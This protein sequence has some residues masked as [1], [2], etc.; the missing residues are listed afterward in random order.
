MNDRVFEITD[1]VCV[2]VCVCLSVCLSAVTQ[3]RLKLFLVLY[4]GSIAWRF[5][6]V[7]ASNSEVNIR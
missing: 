6:V 3:E 4:V 1:R 7:V 2:C 5:G